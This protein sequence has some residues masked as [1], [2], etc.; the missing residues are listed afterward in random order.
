MQYIIHELLKLCTPKKFLRIG[1]AP[2]I[3]VGGTSTGISPPILLRIFEYSK[4]MLVALRSLSLKP[5]SFGYKTPPIRFSQA[6][7]QSA[8]KARPPNLELASTPL[9]ATRHRRCH[10]VVIS[11]HRCSLRCLS[12]D[13]DDAPPSLPS[14]DVCRC[15]KLTART[16]RK[17]CIIQRS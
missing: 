17:K 7:G 3:L 10:A 13:P 2:N 5:I 8:H 14:Y 1:P 15:I 11:I 9:P 6:G 12:V 4:P 16:E